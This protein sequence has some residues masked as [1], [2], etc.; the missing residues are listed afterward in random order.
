MTAN[1][2][3]HRDTAVH[4]A[5]ELDRAA[6]REW[7]AGDQSKAIEIL[8]KA[9]S[10]SPETSIALRLARYCREA[11]RTTEALLAIGYAY[12]RCPGR[13]EVAY[14]FAAMLFEADAKIRAL[15]VVDEILDR[16]PNDARAQ[17]MLAEWEAAR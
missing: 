8:M 7:E 2:T 9:L 4:Q 11:Q 3:D 17:S 12:A 14:E 16:S 1:E 5:C 10:I 13:N 6:R 15:Q